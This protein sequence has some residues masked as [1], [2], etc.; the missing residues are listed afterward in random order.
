MKRI[1]IVLL[2]CILV[3]CGSSATS[4]LPSPPA[5]ETVGNTLE[6]TVHYGE[7]LTKILSDNARNISQSDTLILNWPKPWIREDDLKALLECR[8]SLC[9]RTSEAEYSFSPEEIV[10]PERYGNDIYAFAQIKEDGGIDPAR[11]VVDALARVVDRKDDQVTFS[12]LDRWFYPGSLLTANLPDTSLQIGDSIELRLDWQGEMMLQKG[13]YS[14]TVFEQVSGDRKDTEAWYDGLSEEEIARDMTL[15]AIRWLPGSYTLVFPADQKV[16]YTYDPLDLRHAQASQVTLQWQDLSFTVSKDD[17]FSFFDRMQEGIWLP[18]L[19]QEGA[20]NENVTAAMNIAEVTAI[21][22]GHWTGIPTI[23]K[24]FH[25][26]QEISVDL[27]LPEGAAVGSYIEV[28]YRYD[29]NSGTFTFLD[30]L[31]T[32]HPDEIAVG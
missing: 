10:I 5:S 2:I 30:C 29:Q 18:L 20:F 21:G 4:S 23:E 11:M 14:T 8:K 22:E 32:D 12:P 16:W 19:F 28:F 26:H 13:E 25:N 1:L 24:A 15:Q 9:F 3:S 6:L 31:F 27:P 7:S 17:D